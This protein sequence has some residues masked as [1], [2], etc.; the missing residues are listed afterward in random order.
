MQ[1]V[2]GHLAD[3]AN[4]SVEGKLNLLGIF[5]RVSSA[6][7]P[8]HLSCALVIL[9]EADAFDR[10]THCPVR[11][12]FIDEDGQEM[13]RMEGMQVSVPDQPAAILQTCNLIVNLRPLTL[14]KA[15][16]H[17][18]KVIARDRLVGEIRLQ[19]DTA[20]PQPAG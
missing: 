8:C 14:S 4:I 11:I 3:A 18:F 12:E 20:Q 16:P 13:F 2:V 6:E 19:I 17:C 15:G 7:F 5:Q 1:F 9:F 10:G